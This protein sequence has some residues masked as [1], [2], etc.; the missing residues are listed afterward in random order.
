MNKINKYIDTNRVMGGDFT[1]A[2]LRILT[3]PSHLAM[4]FFPA[5][6]FIIRNILQDENEFR[7]A[8]RAQQ[9]Y[10]YRAAA[11]PRTARYNA[12]KGYEMHY[13]NGWSVLFSKYCKK[14][15]YLIKN[16][17][18]NQKQQVVVVEFNM[19]LLTFDLIVRYISIIN[20]AVIN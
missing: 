19:Y 20:H 4:Y 13:C 11:G 17:I 15:T 7:S 8:Y 12:E 3:T 2:V 10:I 18:R 9:V 16:F 5:T 6:S 14:P 1:A